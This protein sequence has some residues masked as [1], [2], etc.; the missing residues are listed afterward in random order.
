MSLPKNELRAHPIRPL[1]GTE[2]PFSDDT[3]S[4]IDDNLAEDASAKIVQNYYEGPRTCL[5][6]VNWVEGLPRVLLLLSGDAG[7]VV[8]ASR[9]VSIV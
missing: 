2:S 9:S 5:C 1:E 6:C 4:V 3:F 8:V 7:R